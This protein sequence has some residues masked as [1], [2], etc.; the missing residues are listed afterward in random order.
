MVAILMAPRVVAQQPAFLTNGLVAYYPFNGNANDESENKNHGIAKDI[1]PGSN[2]FG[3]QNSS[4]YFNGETSFVD[5]GNNK[6][7]NFGKSDFTISAWIRCDGLQGDKYIVSKYNGVSGPSYGVG[8]HGNNNLYSFIWGNV[9]LYTELKSQTSIGQDKWHQ[10]T[11]VFN[12]ASKLFTYI[13]GLVVGDV[14]IS[15]DK[16]SVIENQVSLLIGSVNGTQ[17]FRGDIDDVR[18]YNRALTDSEAKALFDYDMA[19]PPTVSTV[20]IISQPANISTD[21][22]KDVYFSITASNAL[23]FQWFKDAKPLPN[24]TNSTLF[25]TKA[26]PAMIGDYYAVASDAHSTA[27][28]SVVSLTINGVDA[29]IWKGLVAYY[30]FNNSLQDESVFGNDAKTITGRETFNSDG[31]KQF[32][33]ISP[34][35]SLKIPKSQQIVTKNKFTLQIRFKKVPTTPS[36]FSLIGVSSIGDINYM[37]YGLGDSIRP[38]SNIKYCDVLIKN[39]KDWCDLVYSCDASD[40]KL[41]VYQ[42]GEKIGISSL[43]DYTGPIT[44]GTVDLF[45]GK[46]VRDGGF[47]P[48]QGY[49]DSVRIFNRVLS[50]SE[51]KNMHLFDSGINELNLTNNVSIINHPKDILVDIDGGVKFSVTATNALTYQWF[52]DRIPLL[53]ETNSDLL[54][55]KATPNMVGEYF[56]I[57]QS[58]NSVSTSSVATLN[59]KGVDYSMWR[60]LVGWFPF[61]GDLSNRAYKINSRISVSG[62]SVEYSQN[63]FNIPN[64]ALR[65]LNKTNVNVNQ[66]LMSDIPVNFYK[67]GTI[68]LWI[69]RSAPYHIDGGD[70]AQRWFEIRNTGTSEPI[71]SILSVQNELAWEP[72]GSNPWAR[73]GIG[74]VDINKWHHY[75]VTSSGGLLKYYLDGRSVGEKRYDFDSLDLVTLVFGAYPRYVDQSLRVYDLVYSD[76]KI[77]NHVLTDD[78]VSRA[79]SLENRL[80]LP[81]VFNS[82]SNQDLVVGQTLTLSGVVIGDDVCFRWQKDG[83]DLFDGD[84]VLGAAKQ[85][86]LI[87][88]VSLQDSGIYKLVARRC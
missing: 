79:Y 3:L 49:V 17:F 48:F 1:L 5:C 30:P 21:L 10:I 60:G 71:A 51:V 32:I 86:L 16:E 84:R 82:P 59:I 22:A 29:G 52:K 67:S 27:T 46:E 8:T 26:R 77:W 45:L 57:A 33:L 20:S 41:I 80:P 34:N 56:A 13:D 35:Y 83:V 37:I 2:R 73:T 64:Y 4:C 58:D 23:S 42:Q 15:S 81:I 88:N 47:P 40:G 87:K 38:H 31:D 9:G 69:R 63:R 76:A 11:F 61:S 70:W 50:D 72:Y 75:V 39:P 7:L 12:R 44:G 24:A 25:L 54:M 19:S 6:S 36:T 18:I 68:S 53:G 62:D 85:S 28:S 66:V 78:D 43:Y 65:V 55:D 74:V 14:D